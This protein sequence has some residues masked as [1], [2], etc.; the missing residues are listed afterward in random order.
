MRPYENRYINSEQAEKNNHNKKCTFI[1]YI[2]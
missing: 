1:L 2:C